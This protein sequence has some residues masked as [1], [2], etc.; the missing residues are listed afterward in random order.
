MTK[1]LRRRSAIVSREAIS[2][3]KELAEQ[4]HGFLTPAA[5]VEAARAKD[6]ALHSRFE[7]DDGAAAD[8]YRLVQARI[9]LAVAVE[10]IPADNNARVPTKV[11]VSLSTD[12]HRGDGGGYRTFV[13]VMNN[14]SQR[15]QLLQDSLIAMENFRE[16]YKQLSELRSVFS[17]IAKA[18]KKIGVKLK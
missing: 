16:K 3:L 2:E 15:N 12:R 9:I 14:E 11:F 4:N 7:W 10:Y 17:S 1:E 8:K 13:D 6:S 5:V 18:K